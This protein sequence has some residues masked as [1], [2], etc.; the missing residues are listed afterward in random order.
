MSKKDKTFTKVLEG[1][2]SAIKF[3]ELKTALKRKGFRHDRTTG[4]H[5]IWVNPQTDRSIN[6]QPRPKDK[7]MAKPYQVRQFRE[8]I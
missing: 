8:L 2:A 4:S 6:I 5:E 3:S 1:D 7:T